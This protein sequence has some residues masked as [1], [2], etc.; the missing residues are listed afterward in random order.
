M[1]TQLLK[2]ITGKNNRT[3]ED[4]SK[5]GREQVREMSKLRAKIILM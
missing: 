3:V 4:M 2:K 1:F 5:W